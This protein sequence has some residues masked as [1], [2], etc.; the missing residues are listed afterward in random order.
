[1]TVTYGRPQWKIEVRTGDREPY[2]EWLELY[3]RR[4]RFRYV[5]R[6]EAETILAKLQRIQPHAQFRI[7]PLA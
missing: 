6:E 3:G 1:M 7:A 2:P 4:Q 5:E